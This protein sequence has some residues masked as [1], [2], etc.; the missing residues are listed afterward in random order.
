MI[1]N[2]SDLQRYLAMDRFALERKDK[3]PKL[4]GDYVFKFEIALRHH[5]Y[6]HNLVNSG[7]DGI[8]N[9]VMLYWWRYWHHR[10]GLRLG[11]T[12]PINTFDGGLRINHYGLIIVNEN[13]RIGKYCDIHQGVNIGMQGL[14]NFDCPTIGDNVWIGPGA[15]IFGRIIIGDNCQ[16][17]ANAVVNK[18]FT[19]N[20]ITIAGIPAKKISNHSNPYV[21]KYLI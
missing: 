17:G 1:R 12:I 21:R 9:K 11:F 8:F 16:I 18:D 6:Y 14:S 19:E 10:L 4:F 5:E 13:A 15:K 3:H 2:K 20:G 7:K